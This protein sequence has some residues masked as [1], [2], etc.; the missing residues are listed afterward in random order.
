MNIVRRFIV[1][2]GFFWAFLGFASFYNLTN[3]TQNTDTW[4]LGI[5]AYGLIFVLPGFRLISMNTTKD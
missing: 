1:G 3:L 5:L 4:M 2:F